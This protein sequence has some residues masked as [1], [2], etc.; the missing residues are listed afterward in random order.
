MLTDLDQIRVLA[1]PLRVRLLVAF[2]VDPKTTKQVAEELGEKP[3]KLYHHVDALEKIGLIRL[4]R[5]RRNRGTLEKYYQAVARRF[6]ASPAAFHAAGAAP[7]EAASGPLG[8]VAGSLLDRTRGELLELLADA[9]SAREV[10]ESGMLAFATI[11]ATEAG[12]K[13][14]R[15]QLEKL[16]EGEGGQSKKKPPADSR[17]YRLTLAYYPVDR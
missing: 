3:T 13:R 15:K 1:D 10:E 8:E 7:G 17:T 16:L 2:A 12:V 6:E 11:H 4:V 5:T 9:D 14:I